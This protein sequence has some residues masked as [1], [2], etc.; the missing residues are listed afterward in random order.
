VLCTPT[1]KK[2]P[3]AAGADFVGLVEFVSKIEGGWTDIDV[4]VAT[5]SVMPKIGRLGKILGPRNLM[6]TPRPA[7]YQRCSRCGERREGGKIS[8]KIDKAGIITLPLAACLL[9]LPR[10]LKM[11]RSSSI[12]WCA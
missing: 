1:R 7:L 11:L 8:F 5:P 6:R 2:L 3:R 12:H 9:S 10:L 4:I